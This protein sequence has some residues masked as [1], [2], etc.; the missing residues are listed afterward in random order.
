MRTRLHRPRG[1]VT[2][3]VALTAL[4][5]SACKGRSDEVSAG[6][7]ADTAA[8]TVAPAGDTAATAATAAPAQPAAATPEPVKPAPDQP[9]AKPAAAELASAPPPPAPK[10]YPPF[11]AKASASAIGVMV[12]PKNGQPIE[13]QHGEENE[14]F[15]WA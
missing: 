15:A 8:A 4:A 10:V 1:V 9:A 5:L 14:C 12:Y 6:A 3:L 13:Q 7:V 2:C 11:D